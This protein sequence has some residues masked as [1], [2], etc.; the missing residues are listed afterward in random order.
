MWAEKLEHI[1]VPTIFFGGGTPSLMPTNV[2]S[3][4]MWHIR[5][6]FDVLPN[7]EITLESNPGTL[8]AATMREFMAA[9]VNRLSVGVQS[10]DDTRLKFMGRIHTAYDAIQLIS[11]AQRARLRVSGDFIYGLPGD[12][13]DTVRQMCDGINK[14]NL[15]HVSMYELT[16]EEN[17]PFGNMDLDMPSN[18]EMANMY[19]AIDRYLNLARYEVSNY[20][21]PTHEC[22]HNFNIWHGAPY[23]GIG[24][25][26]AGRVFMNNTW[27][28]Q[29]GG[30]N[31][32]FSP[33]TAQ[34]RATEIVLTG[35][36]TVVGIELTDDIKSVLNMDYIS[37][38]PEYFIVNGDQMRATKKGMLILDDLLVNCIR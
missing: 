22:K 35:T 26:A 30:A 29:T 10:L 12:T 3:K 8:D 19:D 25:G 24:A 15:T 36:R 20:S 4:I 1:T 34:Q 5:K 7:A 2:F 32:I 17:T 16:I 33:L 31:G 18:I 23:I 28:E 27:Y 11:D 9:G 13:V 14:L 21:V 37:S 38:H 6:N